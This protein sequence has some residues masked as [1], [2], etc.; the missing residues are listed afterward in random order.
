MDDLSHS[1]HRKGLLYGIAAYGIWGVVPLYFHAVGDAP[2]EQILAH[3]IVWSVI[4]LALL[5]QLRHRWSDLGRCMWSRKTGLALLGS[6]I[7]VAGN[8][9]IYIYG[10][11]SHQVLQTSLGYFINPLVNVILGMVFF[12]ERLRLL[13]WVAVGLAALGV[14]HLTLASDQ[15]PW[16]ALALGFSFAFYGLV[17]KIIQVDSLLG[18]TT[19]TLFLLPVALAC[20]I[21]WIK[22]DRSAFGSIDTRLD[23]LLILSG[24]I[25]AIPLLFFGAA[26]RRLPLS[27]LGFLQYLAPTLQFLLAVTFFNE[28]FEST[29]LISFLLIWTALIFYSFDSWF[30]LRARRE[31]AENGPSGAKRHVECKPIACEATS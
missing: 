11:A 22:V 20:Q 27:L 3:R 5:I 21:Y 28:P 25:T 7:L 26:A 16:I 19:E 8:W 4:F 13:Q 1:S 24:F 6:A 9:F 15:F 14:V 12:R 2:P 10:I 30:A 31:A 29:K 23:I 17:R 18:L